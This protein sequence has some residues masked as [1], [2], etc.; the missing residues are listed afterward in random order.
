MEGI[1]KNE[2]P[3]QAFL[4]KTITL[5]NALLQS[6]NSPN[7]SFTLKKT[8]TRA[9]IH[10]AMIQATLSSLFYA[11]NTMLIKQTE[12]LSPEYFS[13]YNF[14]W[15][16]GLSSSIFLY[17][18]L[19]KKEPDVDLFAFDKIEHKLWCFIR[20]F[21][22]YFGFVFFVFGLQL[23][24]VST[25]QVLCSI[26]PV[27]SLLVSVT[28]LKE[29]FYWRYIV[30]VLL[31]FFGSAIILGNEK[32]NSSDKKEEFESLRFVLGILSCCINILAN[33]FVNVGQKVLTNDKMSNSQ[34]VFYVSLS[35]V[36]SSFVICLITWNFGFTIPIMLLST[37]NGVFFYYA[38]HFYQ[39]ALKVLNVGG[40]VP[41]NYMI[42]IFIF[43]LCYFILK[44]PLFWTDILGSL[45]IVS[46]HGYNAWKPIDSYK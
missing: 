34:Q 6:N 4:S 8:F 16:R 23:L 42:N 27:V 13:P 46:F 26:A 35:L 20:T 2:D 30:G 9:E 41:F 45:V 5:D 31:C 40:C 11:L 38:N 39:E 12:M 43:I 24:R 37:L 15:W 18:Y 44:E 33:G 17:F 1:N 29:K 14:T 36:I 25:A 32:K 28:M 7:M 21:G 19:K 10:Y 3:K 22:F